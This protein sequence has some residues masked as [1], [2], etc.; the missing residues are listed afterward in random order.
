MKTPIGIDK[1]SGKIKLIN[2][3]DKG[4]ACNCRCPN[5]A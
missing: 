1:T 5:D 2:E 4:L 3:V